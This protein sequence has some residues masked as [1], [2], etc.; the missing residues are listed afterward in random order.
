MKSFLASFFGALMAL[1]VFAFGG[2]FLLFLFF[3]VI[4]ASADK[5]PTAVV[6]DGSFLVLDLATNVTDAPSP[7]DGNAKLGGFLGADTNVLQLRAAVD[8]LD[9]AAQDKQIRGLFITGSFRPQGYGSGYG[10]LKELREA[11]ERFGATKK[12]VIAYA[13]GLDN[14][15]YYVKSAAR[16]LILHPFGAVEARGLAALPMFLA[17]TFEKIGVGVQVTRAGRYKDAAET[18]TRKSFSPESKE[19]LQK[20]LDDV[21]I[22][23]RTKIAEGRGMDAE[24]FQ[25]LVDG[26][27]VQFGD[28]AVKAGLV[29]RLA[30]WDEVLDE[31]KEQTGPAAGGHTFKQISIHAYAGHT[32]ER[33]NSGTG[34][35][36]V[37]YA[38]GV[39]VD[40]DGEHD[41]VGGDRFARALRELRHDDDIKAVVLRVNSPGGSAN[42]SEVIQRELR[43]LKKSKPVVVSMGSVAASGGYWISAYADKIYAQPSTITGSIGVIGVLMNIDE[44]S[45]K[46]GVSYDVVKTGKFADTM[47]ISR[48]KTKEEME[49]IQSVVDWL[50]NGFL[51]RVSEGRKL[52]RAK[53]KE[54][55][56]GR[57]WSGA[58]ALKLGL[59]DEVGSLEDAVKFA[60]VKAGLGVKFRL[61]EFPRKRNF[62]EF[63]EEV[64]KEPGNLVIR[65]KNPTG[66][67]ARI[68]RELEGQ[69]RSLE[70]FNDP[71]SVYLRMP[72]DI[73]ID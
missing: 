19:A 49:S 11:I 44:L 8:A 45:A 62:G 58:D 38:E 46:I 26:T 65:Q 4:A 40:G 14:R 50:Y 68:V 52:D 56:E 36:A 69:V 33:H 3:V 47:T 34:K 5:T 27:E 31:L 71:R 7:F 70:T 28:R 72:V 39:I 43:L 54:I 67:T 51:D 61:Q 15:D 21:W 12:P 17:G 41:Q 59:V 29:D 6:E 32:A 73:R 60:A 64:F 66:A 2:A 48:P 20:L 57:V 37:V 13:E 24:K 30:Y 53:V 18:L 16:D 1:V 55:A 22:E 10:A 25:A 9:A 42:A 23:L 35:V 63:L